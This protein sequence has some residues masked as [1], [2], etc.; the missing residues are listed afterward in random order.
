ME[1]ERV[2]ERIEELM[3]IMNLVERLLDL[4]LFRGSINNGSLAQQ[5]AM[6]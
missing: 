6:G 3:E 4:L 5:H 2:C 1:E